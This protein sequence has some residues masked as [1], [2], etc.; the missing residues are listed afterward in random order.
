MTEYLSYQG[1]CNTAPPKKKKKKKKTNKQTNR[2]PLISI[3]KN[4]QKTVD[5]EKD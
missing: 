3:K 1:S 2:R 4:S 5:S